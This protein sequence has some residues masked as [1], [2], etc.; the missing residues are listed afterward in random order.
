MTQGW[1]DEVLA[2]GLVWFGLV[3]WHRGGSAC[4]LLLRIFLRASTSRER[5][6]S[7]SFT[8]WSA[9]TSRLEHLMS[10]QSITKGACQWGCVGTLSAWRVVPLQ[11]L[12]YRCRKLLLCMY[13]SASRIC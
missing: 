12:L 2:W 10:L 1:C 7:A 11:P 9:V 5:P 13:S 4:T 8:W 3:W 6:K